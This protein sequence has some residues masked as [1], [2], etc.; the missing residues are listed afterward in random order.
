MDLSQISQTRN[1]LGKVGAALCGLLF[2]ALLDGLIAQFRQPQ[3]VFKVL[4]G[5]T[6][7]ING[8]MAGEVKSVQ[9]VAYTSDSERLRLTF[10]SL[11]KGYFLGGDMWRGELTV[12]RD[13]APGEYRLTVAPKGPTLE[14]PLPPFR[15]IVYA[16]AQARRQSSTSMIQRF[17][18]YSPWVVAPAFLLLILP[19][20]GMVFYLS[21]KR[22]ALMARQGKAEV[23]RAVRQ[24]EG[25][26]IR[27]G[28]GTVHGVVPG[29]RVTVSDEQDRMVA[30]AEVT[31]ASE[32]DSWAM[33][34]G[35]AEIKAG[36]VVSMS[37]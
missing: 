16:D 10:L 25:W 29:V 28:L 6:V 15:I 34:S 14:K 37:G 11:H 26:A 21:Q 31:E 32:T 1:L 19:A 35:E 30:A 4:P 27:F 17:T 36:Y 13:I 9:E 18:G 12:N 20:F 2:L 22:E 23:Y 33:A 3:N 8:P 24:E 5:E 7:E